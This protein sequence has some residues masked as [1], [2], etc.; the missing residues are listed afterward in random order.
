M[1]AVGMN[2]CGGF[3]VAQCSQI[4]KLIG[5]RFNALVIVTAVIL[6]KCVDENFELLPVMAGKETSHQMRGRMF[7]EIR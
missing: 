5:I 1:N 3:S 4:H 7:A 2:P 6:A